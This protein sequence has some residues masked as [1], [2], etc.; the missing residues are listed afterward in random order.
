MKER[1]AK[2]QE[3]R[4]DKFQQEMKSIKVSGYPALLMWSEQRKLTRLTI[5]IDD[6]ASIRLRMN[7]SANAN[8]IVQLA[9]E[10]NLKKLAKLEPLRPTEQAPGTQQPAP[11][12]K[13]P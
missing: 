10:L 1:F 9:K 13:T 4:G 2:A 11:G 6:K 7:D 12:S 3:R 5:I 8:E